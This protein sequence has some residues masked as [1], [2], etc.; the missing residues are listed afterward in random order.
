V[1]FIKAFFKKKSTPWIP[2]SQHHPD[3][4][5]ARA[6]RD[7]SERSLEAARK[8]HVDVQPL[9]QRLEREAERNH[10]LFGLDLAMKGH[11]PHERH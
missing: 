2:D 11:Y 1:N 10:F 9:V 3:I 7:Q 6:A 8:K 4:A 5:S